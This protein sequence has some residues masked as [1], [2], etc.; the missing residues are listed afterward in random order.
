M[1][2]SRKAVREGLLAAAVVGSLVLGAT[3]CGGEDDEPGKAA[4]KAAD[5]AVAGT[6][7][8]GGGGA[9]ST[10][11]AKALEVITG[12]SRF[13]ASGKDYTLAKA[14][15]AVDAGAPGVVPDSDL[16]R[17]H[18]PVGTPEVELRITWKLV[19]GTATGDTASKFTVLK[20]GEMAV[21]ATNSALLQFGCESDKVTATALRH[22]LIDVERRDTLE[23]PEGDA[24]A[25]K[26]AY[27]TVAH[28]LALGLA[29]ELH[30]E[31]NGGLPAQAV[32]DAA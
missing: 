1:V 29:K 12:E 22:I 8:C 15:A 27:A 7:L 23:E 10:E 28:S 2:I 20:M 32:L 14:A 24:E 9:V 26:D 3:A 30:C 19:D 17:I 11:A 4:D 5:K 13:E 21:T 31:E 25:L 16:C 6:E 18:T